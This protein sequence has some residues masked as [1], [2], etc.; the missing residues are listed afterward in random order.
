MLLESPIRI[1]TLII[2]NLHVRKLYWR[3]KKITLGEQRFAMGHWLKAKWGDS[4]GWSFLKGLSNFLLIQVCKKMEQ[5]G[6]LGDLGVG[7]GYPERASQIEENVHHSLLRGQGVGPP[8]YVPQ[9]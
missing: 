8:C 4:W 2:T 6:C 9:E 3:G 1:Q 7:V 5:K